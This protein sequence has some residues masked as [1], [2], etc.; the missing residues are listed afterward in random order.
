MEHEKRLKELEDHSESQITKQSM[1]EM[2]EE[3]K[4]PTLAEESI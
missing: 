1:M 3:D 2:A 4:E